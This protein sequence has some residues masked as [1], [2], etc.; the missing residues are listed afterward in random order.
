MEDDKPCN[1]T[2]GN[3]GSTTNEYQQ[4]INTPL[5]SYIN[6]ND[7]QQTIIN[8]NQFRSISLP[9]DEFHFGEY[10]NSLSCMFTYVNLIWFSL[11]HIFIYSYSHLN[12][13]SD[14]YLFVWWPSKSTFYRLNVTKRDKIDMIRAL[15]MVTCI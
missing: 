3:H 14:L 13:P 8:T 7:D 6:M 11:S 9:P 10:Q 15:P 1:I 12:I 2:Q 5:H 4:T